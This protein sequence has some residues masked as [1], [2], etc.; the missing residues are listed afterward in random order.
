MHQIQASPRFVTLS[1]RHSITPLI[2]FTVH[3]TTRSTLK[4]KLLP[5]FRRVPIV[6]SSDA[7]SAWLVH[8]VVFTSIFSHRDRSFRLVAD[9]NSMLH[10]RLW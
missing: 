2:F 10:H 1:L 4:M 6:L 8:H 7:E 3:Q 9:T 5:Q